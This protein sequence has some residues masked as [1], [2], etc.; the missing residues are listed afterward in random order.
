MNHTLKYADLPP[1]KSL[2]LGSASPRRRDLLLQLMPH[3]DIQVCPADIDES[4]LGQESGEA[5][6]LRLAQAKAAAVITALPAALQ[7]ALV[8]TADTEVVRDGHPLGKPQ[9]PEHAVEL[10]MQLSGHHHQV[11]TALV[12]QQGKQ[13]LQRLVTTEVIF[14]HLSI[15]EIRA[16][17]ATGEPDDKAGGYGIQGRGAALVAG[18]QGSYSNVVGLPLEALADMLPQMGYRIF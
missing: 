4:L 3:L 2:V 10:L 17:V 8:L 7:G 12:L 18:I 11:K 6:V 13:C 14:R 15:D 1:L 16:Y 5:L 9:S